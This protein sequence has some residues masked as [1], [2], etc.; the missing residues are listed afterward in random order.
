MKRNLVLATLASVFF[1]SSF[2][3]HAQKGLT[4]A[5]K[6]YDQWAYIE[7]TQLLEKVIEKGFVSQDVLEKLGNAYYF[8]ARYAEA[9]KHYQRLFQDF[10]KNNI[11]SAFYYRYAHTLQH[12]G[13][14]ELA[15][16]YFDAFV[17]QTGAATQVAKARKNTAEQQAQIQKNSGRYSHVLGLPFN[18]PQADYGSFVH[19]TTLYFTSARDTGSFSKKTHTWTN[20]S[21]TN[22]YAYEL[23]NDQTNTTPKRIKGQVSSPFNESTAI[24]TADGQ[25]MYFTK[26]NTVNR[27]RKSD[28]HGNTLLKIYKAVLEDKKWR[29]VEELPFNSDQFNTAHPYLSK[30]EKTMYFVSDRPGGYGNA[31]LWKV[32]VFDNGAFGTPENLGPEINTEARETFPFV[33]PNNELYFS[34]DGRV[35]LGGLDV[36]GVKIYPDGSFGEVQNVGEPIN[37]TSDDF[38]YYIDTHTNKGFFSSNRAG[39]RGND[40]IYSFV[41]TRALALEC[42]PQLI[43]RVLDAQT[44][45]TLEKTT[46]ELADKSYQK[47][48]HEINYIEP[49]LAYQV[50]GKLNCGESFRIKGSKKGY[51]SAE[52][53]FTLPT[54]SGEMVVTLLLEPEKIEVKKGDDLFKVL[55]LNPIYFDL[56]K[57]NIRKDAAL[58]LAKVLAVLEE[59][60]KMKIDI[61]SHTDSR[62]SHKYNDQLSERRAKSTR[63]WLIDN[64]ISP[65][66]L[67]SKGYGERQLIN[68]CADGVSCSEQ[69]HQANRR[70]EFIIIEM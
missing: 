21:F 59:Y 66:R 29:Q 65:S 18:T 3:L 52:T 67:T 54:E 47:V 57:A 22:L 2:Q 50:A 69:E 4:Q 23:D 39:G 70:S 41:E 11:S 51:I 8:N 6:S 61:R 49:R 56:D 31:D 43:V 33:T 45:E 26:N 1:L 28:A 68:K 32:A 48:A 19:N 9:Q 44:K 12:V 16:T 27:K 17:E 42:V 58:E 63:K 7:S 40:D 24:I 37:S 46:L 60:P 62:A 20:A 10:S 64:G 55:N 25:T 35:G 36:F 13:Q 34:T 30:D 14:E 38:A 5:N 15:K 53:E